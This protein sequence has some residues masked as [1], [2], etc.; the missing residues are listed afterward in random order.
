M[1]APPASMRARSARRRARLSSGSSHSST[2]AWSA[3]SQTSGHGA[4]GVVVQERE[5]LPQYVGVGRPP[6][7]PQPFLAEP[8]EKGLAYESGVGVPERPR[9]EL[10]GAEPLHPPRHDIPVG[11]VH[12]LA[13]GVQRRRRRPGRVLVDHGGEL[14]TRVALADGTVRHRHGD[15]GCAPQR[16]SVAELGAGAG[17]HEIGLPVLPGHALRKGERGDETVLSRVRVPEVRRG[18]AAVPSGIRLAEV[19]RGGPKAPHLRPPAPR[20]GVAATPSSP[21]GGRQVVAVFPGRLLRQQRDHL[22]PRTGGVQQRPP[23]PGMQSQT[24]QPCAPGR[25][26]AVRVHRSDGPQ[27]LARRRHRATRRWVQQRETGRVRIAPAGHLQRERRQVGHLD[28]RRRETRQP[29]VLRLC[30]A[31]V[32]RAGRLTPRPSG[33]LPPGRL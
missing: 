2:R 3:S 4:A 5:P 14:H 12:L 23:Q 16:G 7:Y 31:P 29:G 28:L 21:Q 26:P 8:F 32:H 20:V 19:R 33:P 15:P 11:P 17:G 1:S 24:G 18:G 13:L 9:R 25:G 30:P 22:G 6:Q 10:D 27:H